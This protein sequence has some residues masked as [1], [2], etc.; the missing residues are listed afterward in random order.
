MAKKKRGVKPVGMVDA[1]GFRGRQLPPQLLAATARVLTRRVAQAERGGT[2]MIR[3][4]YFAAPGPART[5]EAFSRDYFSGGMGQYPGVFQYG[6]GET[7]TA[8]AAAPAAAPAAPS[9]WSTVQ[10]LMP[11]AVAAIQKKLAPKPAEPKAA[12]PK[13]PKPVAAPPAVVPPKSGLPS[14]VT[15]V[16]IGAGV[17]VLGVGAYMVLRK[18]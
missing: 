6:T 7:S 12:K 18:K 11:A 10:S 9:L 1:W 3:H 13:A 15:P 2:S 5:T 17:L 16:A 4:N 14:W 8:T